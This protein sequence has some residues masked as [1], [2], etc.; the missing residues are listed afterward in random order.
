MTGAATTTPGLASRLVNGI[1]AIKPLANLAKHQARQMMIKRA[2]KI[3]VPWTEEVKILQARDWTQE[4]AKVHNP[5]ISYPDY[6]LNSF[7][8]YENGN[9]SWQAAFELKP[10]AHAV[11]AKIWQDTDAQG[12]TK[13]RQSY[14]NIL[15]ISLPHIPQDIL[16][17]GC[18]VGLS[19][20]ALQET[21]PHSQI[22]GLDLS[23]YFLAVAY[24]RAQERQGKINW[25]HTA[26]ESNGLPDASFDLVSI[27]LM[28]HELPQSATRNIFAQMRRV[29]RS[30]GHLAIMDMNP[31]SEIYH[32]MPTYIL[33]LL[34]ST[35]PYLDQ[36][37]SLDIHQALLE[38]GFQV[39]TITSNTP[40]HR[41]I[42]A[43]V[44]P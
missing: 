32:K 37:F 41:T 24:H 5:Q 13:L 4:L 8:A 29:L 7:H 15:K 10:A 19:T 31:Q 1:L 16:D 25:L 6:Y 43:Q 21:Y 34:K 9:L 2:E 44:R 3:G 18:G 17:V 20:F 28:C 36:Y 12:D 42:I 35:E 22:T 14:H 39:P 40:R 30:G 26:A 23:P 27:F 33:T 11:H 38:A